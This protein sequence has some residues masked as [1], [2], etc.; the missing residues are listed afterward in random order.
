MDKSTISVAI[1]S[2]FFVCLPEGTSG[3]KAEAESAWIATFMVDHDVPYENS[4]AGDF[5]HFWTNLYG[6][7]K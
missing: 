7:L 2:S 4:Y 3:R 5:Y 1:F 6:F